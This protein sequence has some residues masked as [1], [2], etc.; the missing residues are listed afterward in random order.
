MI[1]AAGRGSRLRPL[2]DTVPKPLVDVGGQSLLERQIIRLVEAGVSRIVINVAYMHETIE[3]AVAVMPI[4]Q[5]VEVIFS[6]EQEGA[7]ETAGG[8]INALPLLGAERFLVVNADVYSEFDFE[9]LVSFDLSDS[10]AHLVMVPVPEEKSSADFFLPHNSNS[11]LL[12]LS[13]EQGLT[14][15]GISVMSQALFAD[16]P[17]QH[18]ALRPVLVSAIENKKVSAEVYSGRWCDVGT[19]DRLELLR[20]QID[21]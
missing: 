9:R 20:A 7:L 2:T 4:V 14:Y 21:G 5:N 18:L 6:R 13:G 3:Q 19:L 1:L 11:G 12:Y 15:S 10:L 16:L 8:I 17:L